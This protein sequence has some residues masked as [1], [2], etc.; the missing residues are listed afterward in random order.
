[1]Q[2]TRQRILEIL[3]ERGEATIE[4]LGE[5]LDLTSVTVRHHLDILRG[6]GLVEVPEV[7][8]RATPGR[9]QYVYILTEAASDF[10]PKNYGSFASL[11][12]AEIRNRY[13]PAE[14]D[15]IL[16][17]MAKRIE[18]DAPG[19][20]DGRFEERLA[21]VVDLLNA[22]GYI[23]RWEKND[24]GYSL[25][26]NNCPYRDVSRD[27]TEVCLMDMTLI[28]DFLG[29]IPERISWTAAGE[30]SCVYHIPFQMI[31]PS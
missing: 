5:A 2:A 7:R 6:E 10:F 1:M 20:V 17:G 27:H 4:E 15:S 16:Q 13:G 9:P 31:P 3:K 8:R 18:K 28:S 22:R 25:R 26:T 24:D 21:R 11:M 14:L 30:N 23:A 19:L 12:I 29:L